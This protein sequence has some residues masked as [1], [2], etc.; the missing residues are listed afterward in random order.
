MA[1]AINDGYMMLLDAV[2]VGS[3]KI[4]NISE[5]GVDWSGD[6]AQ[7]TELNAAQVR[8]APVK[9]IPRKAATNVLTFRLIELLPDH[10]KN[11]MGGEVNGDKWNA[12]ANL[13]TIEDSVKILTGTGQTIDITQATVTAAVR[14]NLGGDSALGIDVRLEVVNDPLGGSPFSMSP[15][16]PFI[17]ATSASLSFVA[18]GESKTVDIEASSPFTV[19]GAVPSGFSVS[20]VS[21]KVTITASA[22]TG[23]AARSGKITFALVSDSS[24]KVE[25]SLT[26][27]KPA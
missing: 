21:G 24:K 26:Q 14:G 1:V 25:I 11:V 17:N 22:N 6:D 16:E 15:T 10:C 19:S 4:G 12:P 27:A 3:K 18:G 13:I 20:V 5:D 23:T 7:F 9:K 8:T 2:F